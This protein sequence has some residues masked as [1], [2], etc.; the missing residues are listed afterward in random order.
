MLRGL[1]AAAA[2]GFIPPPPPWGEIRHSRINIENDTI[3]GLTK[4]AICRKKKVTADGYGRDY[5]IWYN[6]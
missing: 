6:G 3:A 4:E 1:R 2:C 5:K